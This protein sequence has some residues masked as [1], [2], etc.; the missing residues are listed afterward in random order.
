MAAFTYDATDKRSVNSLIGR[1]YGYMFFGLVLT[2][3]IAFGV[4]ILFNLWI[5]KTIDTS[6][7]NYGDVEANINASGAIA[8]LVMLVV[9][10][11]SLF[12][13]SFVV[14]RRAMSNNKS[15][16]I[17]ALIYCILMG[18]LL[19]ELVIFIPWQILGITFA[20]TAGIYGIMFLISYI[21]KGS[22]HFLGVLGIGLLIGGAFL[23]LI[24]FILGMVGFLGAYMHL[25]W[26]VS[27]ITFA[28]IM[29]ITI[30]DM[31]RIKQIAEQGEMNDNL[32]LYCAFILYVDF[33]YLFLRVLRIV[34]LIAGRR[35]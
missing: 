21:S 2:A 5:F 4:G 31:W 25:Y 14:H 34:A 11:I 28:A 19:S 27:L 18:L 13:M 8:L 6:N 20:I 12:I 35:R 33:V 16:Q 10:S 3:V 29:F 15:L 24:G 17:P 9:T 23:G 1:V 26:I 22:L 32:V 30:W 7:I